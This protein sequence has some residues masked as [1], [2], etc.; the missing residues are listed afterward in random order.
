MRIH[1]NRF[2]FC[3]HQTIFFVQRIFR[4]YNLQSL[5][6]KDSCFPHVLHREIQQ[7]TSQNTSLL[8]LL[9]IH[10]F[11]NSSTMCSTLSSYSIQ[12]FQLKSSASLLLVGC[13]WLNSFFVKTSTVTRYDSQME[14]L[15]T[16]RWAL[17][18][19]RHV[20]VLN[21]GKGRK[22]SVVVC[23]NRDGFNFVHHTIK[24]TPFNAFFLTSGYFVNSNT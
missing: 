3:C 14:R 6:Q 23:E 1:Y 2:Q 9:H 12:Q 13:T 16:C 24:G 10:R 22:L 15:Y 11:F 8:V 4:I 17:E 19:D 5:W 21:Y 18:R 7:E 20:I